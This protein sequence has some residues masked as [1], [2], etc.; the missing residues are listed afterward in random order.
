VP[1][2]TA[3]DTLSVGGQLPGTGGYYLCDV[4]VGVDASGN[5]FPPSLYWVHPDGGG[6]QVGEVVAPED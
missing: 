2:L 6:G 5:A 3:G 4:P 1:G